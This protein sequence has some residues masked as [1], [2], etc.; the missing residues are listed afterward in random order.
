MPAVFRRP[1]TTLTSPGELVPFVSVL[2]P[3]GRETRPDRLEGCWTLF[4]YTI[5]TLFFPSESSVSAVILTPA[6]MRAG[7][8][9]P[10]GAESRTGPDGRVHLLL[11]GP[12]DSPLAEA[13]YRRDI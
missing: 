10:A 12:A 13:E 11:R 6:G 1:A 5:E 2:A 3:L 7:T 8:R 4:P 9:L